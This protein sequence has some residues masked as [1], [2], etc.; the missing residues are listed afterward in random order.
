VSVDP[1]HGLGAHH[2]I[3]DCL[4]C[5]LHCRFEHGIRFAFDTI[6]TVATSF[7]PAA[8]ALPVENAMNRSPDPSPD[9]EPVRPS[10]SVARRARRFV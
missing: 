2:R 10:P 7:D 3:D 6:C 1:G 8:F 4:F 9:I 5:R